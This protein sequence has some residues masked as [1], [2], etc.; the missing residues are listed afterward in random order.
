MNIDW[1][2]LLDEIKRKYALEHDGQL[3]E[4]LWMTK[5]ALSNYRHGRMK[6]GPVTRLIVLMKC[7]Y[8]T[9][10]ESLQLILGA[11]EYSKIIEHD[12]EAIGKNMA[13][14]SKQQQQDR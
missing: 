5:S 4:H 8:P 10:R 7:G 6:L 14:L 9:A 1:D 11:D 3:A 12:N 2:K 13:T